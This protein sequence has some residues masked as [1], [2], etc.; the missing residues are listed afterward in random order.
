MSRPM[1]APRTSIM[2]GSAWNAVSASLGFCW[3]AWSF[4][5]NAGSAR[6]FAVRGFAA[7]L[8]N[9]FGSPKS[10][11]RPTASAPSPRSSASEYAEGQRDESGRWQTRSRTLSIYDL[12]E[13]LAERGAVLDLQTDLVRLDSLVVSPQAVQR[14]ALARI[15]LR[16]GRVDFDTLSCSASS[17]AACHCRLPALAAL[18]LDQRTKLLGSMSRAFEKHS[19]ALS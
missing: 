10:L 13:A 11:P 9:M 14:R 7:S 19:M 2:R 8:A 16:P 5:T 1:S 18:R 6:C 12:L 4:C 3:N 17:S 15:P